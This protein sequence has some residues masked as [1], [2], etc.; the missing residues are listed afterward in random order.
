MEKEQNAKAAKNTKQEKI[1]STDLFVILTVAGFVL[2]VIFGFV[3]K[4]IPICIVV[5][6]AVGAAAGLV[7]D[8]NRDKKDKQNKQEEEE[9]NV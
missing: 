4:S 3:L 1:R 7:L 6:T 8:D 9:R 2:G 5:G